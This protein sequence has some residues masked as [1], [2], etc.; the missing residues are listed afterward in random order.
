[1]QQQFSGP[2]VRGEE[3]CSAGIE[4]L[5]LQS[6]C[7]QHF[8]GRAVGVGQD[9]LRCVCWALICRHLCAM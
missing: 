4:A 6:K 7:S 8:L 1:M 3:A 2:T 9:S 5:H